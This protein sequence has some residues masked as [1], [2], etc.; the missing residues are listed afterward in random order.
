MARPVTIFQSSSGL[1]TRLD[2]SRVPFDSQTGLSDLAVAYNVDHDATGRIS[3]RKGYSPTAVTQ[4][5]HSLWSA[6]DAG[7]CFFVSGTTLYELHTDFST[8]ALATVTAGGRVRYARVANQTFWLNGFEKGCIQYGV[9]GLWGVGSYYGPTTKRH[10]SAP[11]VGHLLAQHRGRI[12]IGQATVAWYSEPFSTNLFDLARSFIPFESRLRMMVSVGRTLFI[13][14]EAATWSLIGAWPGEMEVV[15]AVDY[16]AIEG[17]ETT[18][19][20]SRFGSGELLGVGAIWTSTRG[21][22]LGLPDGQVFNLTQRKINL[23]TANVGAGA[24][25]G[26]RYVTLLQP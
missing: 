3:R 4:A 11:P 1:N 23:P 25:V 6:G 16:P 19:D 7:P 9:N 12:W 20:L 5:S 17:T 24:V 2:P 10:L 22:C 15:K 13:S 18:F 26:D 14:D 21:I 8:T